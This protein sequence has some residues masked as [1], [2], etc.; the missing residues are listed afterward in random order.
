MCCCCTWDGLR[1]IAAVWDFAEKLRIPAACSLRG[2]PLF[3]VLDQNN[4]VTFGGIVGL[5]QKGSQIPKILVFLIQ[6]G[7]AGQTGI[8]IGDQ[9]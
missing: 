8:L 6:G 5:D 7:G 2:L 3:I 9:F 4:L 1:I